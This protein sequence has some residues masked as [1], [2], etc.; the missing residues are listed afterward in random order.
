MSFIF[1]GGGGGGTVIMHYHVSI[2]VPN[3]C[4]LKA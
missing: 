1:L 2:G 4:I 3:K